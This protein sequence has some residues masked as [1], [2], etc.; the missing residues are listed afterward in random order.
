MTLPSSKSRQGPLRGFI[1]HI[2]PTRVASETVRF[3]LT[4]G[5][6]GMAATLVFLLFITGILQIFSYV[7]EIS[8]AYTSVQAM[9][10]GGTLSGW[11]RNIHYWSGNLLVICT[12]LHACRVVFTG[13][14]S[15]GRRLNWLVGL[16]LFTLVFA[17]N[18]TGYLLPWDQ[19]SYWA[20]TIFLNMLS[21]IPFTG[22]SLAQLLRGGNEI[23]NATIGTFY[24]IH[25]GA[26]PL[27]FFPLLIFHF[28]LIRRAGGV[29]RKKEAAPSSPVMIPVLPH[30]IIREAAVGLGII[31]LLLLTSALVDAP[32]AEHANPGIS[33]NPAKAAWFLM[34]LQELLLH[35]HPLYAICVFPALGLLML[36]LLPFRPDSGSTQGRWF[37]SNEGRRLSIKTALSS[38]FLTFALVYFD[39]LVKS[40]GGTVATDT[41]TRGFLPLVAV[42]LLYAAGYY[43]LIKKFRYSSEQAVM[44]GFVF[45]VTGILCLTVTGIALR[46][47]GMTLTFPFL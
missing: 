30:L 7:P 14:F 21:Y 8:G 25:T 42:I 46:G 10:Q 26:L 32:L 20:G 17:A 36:L 27:L 22:E 19:L 2:H 35:L 45:T 37:G 44:A 38:A 11:I 5:L 3:T 16:L 12:V 23:G 43:L 13:A 6:G 24:A 29:I 41:F 33:P 18:F 4:F 34:G 28:W 40:T 15:A 1:L 31:A 47:P 39:E 9:K